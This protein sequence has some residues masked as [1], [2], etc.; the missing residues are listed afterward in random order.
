MNKSPEKVKAFPKIPPVLPIIMIALVSF[1]VYFNA[2]SNGFIWDDEELII[3]NY[4][5]KDIRYLPTIFT[6][7][8]FGFTESPASNYYRPVVSLMYMIN[9]HV[10][11]LNPIIY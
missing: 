11:G 7:S 3:N 9:Y 4:W 6:H 5:I 2:L 8:F 1:G 10:F